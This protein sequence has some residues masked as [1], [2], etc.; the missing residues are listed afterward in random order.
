MNIGPD[1]RGLLPDADTKRLLELGEKIRNS[2]GNPL[3]YTEPLRDGDIYTMS[4]TELKQN[5]RIP[6]EERLSNCL[7]LKEDLQNG[8]SIRSFR[9]YGYL[10]HYRQKKIL[11]FEGRTVGHKVYCRFPA[12]RCSKFEVEITDYD[13]A[14]AL[15]DIKAFYVR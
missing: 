12:L 1:N 11:L 8:Q 5:W 3:P 7:M 15:K 10:P 13:G 6:K 2:Y 14:Y 9:I 4:H